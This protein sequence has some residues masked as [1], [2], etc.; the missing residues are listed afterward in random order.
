M[1]PALSYAITGLSTSRRA[2]DRAAA[3]L[4]NI[5]SL[6]YRA[7]EHRER[8][9]AVLTT[10]NPLDLAVQGDGWFR[11]ASFNGSAFGEVLYTRAGDF[12]R[13]GNGHVVAADGRYVIGYALDSTGRPT[14]N[15]VPIRIPDGTTSVSV[16]PDGVVTATDATGATTR[17]AAISLA[18]FPNVEGLEAAG[19]GLYRA[20]PNSGPAL[21]GTAG[22]GAFGELATGAVEASNVDAAETIVDLLVAR[23]G[24]SASVAAFETADDLLDDLVRLGR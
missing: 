20:S 13:D 14:V 17:I 9:G 5:G 16:G 4:A 6:G 7:P 19:G 24:F 18:R 22:S 11:V 8:P 1:I 23:H 15:E 3:D 2:V 10:G 21:T 12:H